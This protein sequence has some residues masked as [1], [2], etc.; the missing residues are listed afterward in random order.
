MNG[1]SSVWASGIS[2]GPQ[3]ES[4]DGLVRNSPATS[5]THAS[6]T[7]TVPPV[8]P[9]GKS[10]R[11]GT[12]KRRKHTRKSSD[13][14]PRSSSLR[15][16]VPAGCWQLPLARVTSATLVGLR[17]PRIPRAAPIYLPPVMLIPVREYHARPPRILVPC[18][19]TAKQG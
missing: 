13:R 15:A 10:P 17:L 11:D 1:R 2:I 14:P 7:T 4:L 9:S 18:P 3:T 12:S 16:Q 6:T 8:S 5:A 19:R